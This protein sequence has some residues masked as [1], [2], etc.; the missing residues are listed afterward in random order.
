MRRRSKDRRQMQYYGDL[1]TN[2]DMAKEIR[3]FN[4][5]DTFI[6][7]YKETFGRYFLGIKKLIYAEG[8]WSTGVSLAGSGVNCAL[9]LYIAKKVYDGAIQVG[10]YTLYTGALTSIASGISNLIS[11]F[12]TIY[13]GTLFIDNMIAFM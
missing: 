9:F 4:L 1:L 2:K 3:I 12:A 13:E 10:D 7:C 8:A 11:T 6:N 5:S